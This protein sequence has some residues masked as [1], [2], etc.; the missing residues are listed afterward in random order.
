MEIWGDGQ[1]KVRQKRKAMAEREK[2]L[3]RGPGSAGRGHR[4]AVSRGR[5]LAAARRLG[6]RR[7][8]GARWGDRTLGGGAGE[9]ERCRCAR[10]G[11]QTPRSGAFVLCRGKP[12]A[13]GRP[14]AGA[15]SEAPRA[16]GLA[17]R[18]TSPFLP[19]PSSAGLGTFAPG[20]APSGDEG[21]AE[22]EGATSAPGFNPWLPVVPRL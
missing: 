4:G 5:W 2:V 8:S 22:G 20:E 1:M 21:A 13:P 7:G 17:T 19:L 9:A 18:E 6:V 11:R 10:L 3:A 14:N 15:S 12:A 16:R